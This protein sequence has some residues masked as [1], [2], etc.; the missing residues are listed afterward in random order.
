MSRSSHVP[1]T[2][3]PVAIHSHRRKSSRDVRGVQEKHLAN[4]GIQAEQQEVRDYFFFKKKICEKEAVQGEREVLSKTLESGFSHKSTSCL[5]SKIGDTHAREDGMI[6]GCH[7][8][9]RQTTSFSTHRNLPQ[10]SGICSFT[11][12]TSLAPSRIKAIP[13]EE[14]L[15]EIFCSRAEGTQE[16]PDTNCGEARPQ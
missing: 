15:K 13:E 12:R 1:S 9:I 5:R 4:E 3:K 7:P 2:G 10:K 14:E 11:K 8:K 16:L 6:S